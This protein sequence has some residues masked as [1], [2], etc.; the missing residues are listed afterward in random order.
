MLGVILAVL[1]ALTVA[2]RATTD[3]WQRQDVNW[4]AG[5]GMSI[6]GIYVPKDRP[7]PTTPGQPSRLQTSVATGKSTFAAI[8]ATAAPAANQVD[9]P[10]VAGFTV[11]IAVAITNAR[12]ASDS[13]WVAQPQSSIVGSFLTS[14]PQT[15]F[16][17]GV[18]DTGGSFHL[19]GYTAAERTGILTANLLS[20]HTIGLQ[21]ATGSVSA[22]VSQPLAVF[23]DGVAAIDPNTMIVNHSH[24]VGQS[25]VTIAVGQQPQGGAADLDTAIG[26][27]MSVNFAAAIFNDRQITVIRD[28]NKY[29]GPD[30]KF[31]DLQDPCI[32]QYANRAGLNLIP[33]G[34]VDVEYF[35]GWPSLI[36]GDSNQSKFFLDTVDL[37]DGAQSA[38]DRHRFL[39]DTGSQITLISSSIS[40]SLNLNPNAPDFKIQ[41]VGITNQTAVIPGFF[42]DTLEIPAV[43]QWFSCAHVPVIVLDIGSVDGGI[44]DG[45]IGTNLFVDFDLVIR[46]GGLSGQAAPS[47]AFQRITPVPAGGIVRH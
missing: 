9:S 5:G 28:G 30:V 6:K 40:A 27:P 11:N 2:A 33:A 32:P 16:A 25:N 31:Y 19:M 46:G 20:A 35:P 26:T 18:F 36:M 29:T 43:G 41:I 44:L 14:H 1:L 4:R 21:G 37:Y 17:I 47:L 45:I 42:I 38:L 39:L 23:I 10:P 22:W 8:S 7:F 12:S 15:D 34:S 13:N 24:M 3:D